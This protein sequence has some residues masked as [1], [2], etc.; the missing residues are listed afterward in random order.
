MTREQKLPFFDEKKAKKVYNQSDMDNELNSLDTDN[1]AT[2]F[3]NSPDNLATSDELQA[4][5]NYVT[6]QG[7]A[8]SI[9]KGVSRALVVTGITV[10][11]SA[12]GY[13]LLS[14]SM[15]S[16]PPS[17]AD[18]SFVVSPTLDS[19]SYFFTI[20]NDKEYKTTFEILEKKE[21]LFSLDVTKADAYSGTAENL[22]Y[23]KTLVYQITYVANDYTGTLLKVNFTTTTK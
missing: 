9:A 8:F 1:L 20:T 14:N 23:G 6:K 19:L 17:V 21:I 2:S 3:D 10:S 12:G 11:V 4:S 13:M 22:G 16:S 15:V 5:E 18:T 7:T